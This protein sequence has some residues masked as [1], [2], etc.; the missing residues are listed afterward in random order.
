MVTC[1][2]KNSK[3]TA[4]TN[5]QRHPHRRH[6]VRSFFLKGSVSIDNIAPGIRIGKTTQAMVKKTY[7]LA[8]INKGGPSLGIVS[9]KKASAACCKEK[10]KGINESKYCDLEDF[11]SA[12]IPVTNKTPLASMLNSREKHISIYRQ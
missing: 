6:A 8:V 1:A 11:C 2:P 4:A 9:H 10:E 12:S 3:H 7:L 5:D